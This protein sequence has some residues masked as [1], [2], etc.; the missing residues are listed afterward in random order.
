MRV[1][2]RR[3]RLAGDLCRQ[4]VPAVHPKANGGRRCQG[5]EH[6]NMAVSMCKGRRSS[7]DVARSLG[8]GLSGRAGHVK[9]GGSLVTSHLLLLL[10]IGEAVKL[11]PKAAS[12]KGQSCRLEKKMR[13]Q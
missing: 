1:F 2:F 4:P 8:P 7:S 11:L 3:D 13:G 5:L 9:G 10:K 6:L 12:F